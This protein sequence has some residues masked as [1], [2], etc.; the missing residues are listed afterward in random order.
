MID[1]LEKVQQRA[2]KLVREVRHLPYPERLSR[3]IVPSIKKRLQR[4][5]M[6]ET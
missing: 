1:L 4:G 6:I 3:L 2:T 5:D